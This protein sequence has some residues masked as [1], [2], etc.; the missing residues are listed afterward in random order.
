MKKR[1]YQKSYV[2]FSIFGAEYETFINTLFEEGIRIWDLE[3]REKIVYAKTSPGSYKKVAR[4][5]KACGVQV[6]I[7]DKGGAAFVFAPIQDLYGLIFGGLAFFG[8]TTLL[9][10]FVW[11]V[12][13][14]G[15]QIISDLQIIQVLEENGVSRGSSVKGI[16]ETLL[17]LKEMLS[18]DDLAWISVERYGSRILV[19]VSERSKPDKEDIPF[20][21]PCNIVATKDAQLIN[22]DVYAGVL[23][24]EEGS[25]IR[26]GEVI[27]SGIVPDGAGN[28]I[29]KHASASILA[30]FEETAEFYQ[31]YNTTETVLSNTTVKVNY[32]DFLGF[33][34]PLNP[35]TKTPEYAKYTEETRLANF[36]IIPLPW[37]YRTGIYTEYEDIEVQRSIHDIE[38]LLIHKSEDYIDTFFKE[39][40]LIHVENNFY[41]DENGVKLTAVYT[42]EGDIG[43]KREILIRG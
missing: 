15:N 32:L 21:T 7:T 39:Y 5:S 26:K 13:I 28:T 2:Q 27:V 24:K 1:K 10:Q 37:K 3:T 43:E 30:R 18:L 8:L 16:D 25:G 9:S 29:I 19:R 40:S 20:S 4:I 23:T 14:Q 11:D 33:T 34:I 31:P 22:A 42:L 41:A 36:F 17:E 35:F 6:R 38:R 12:D